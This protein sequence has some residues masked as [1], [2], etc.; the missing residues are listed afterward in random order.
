MSV[1]GY[2]V[3]ARRVSPVACVSSVASP[4]R[5]KLCLSTATPCTPAE[6]H[7]WRVSGVALPAR[8]RLCL[9]T[10]IPCT[11]AQYH[12]WRVGSAASPARCRLCLS[13]ATPMHTRRVSPAACKQCSIACWLQAMSIYI[14]THAAPAALHLQRARSVVSIARCRLCL[15]FTLHHT[16]SAPPAACR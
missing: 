10:A 16:C 7:L 6:Y 1:Y 14:H 4:A 9:S 8:C 3:H 13:I 12:L 11:P 2:T 5:C 15:S